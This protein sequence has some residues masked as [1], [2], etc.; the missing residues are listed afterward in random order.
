MQSETERKQKAVLKAARSL[1]RD[2]I[3][4]ARRA[5][6]DEHDI[7]LDLQ[8]KYARILCDSDTGELHEVDILVAQRILEK[9]IRTCRRIY[10]RAHPNTKDGEEAL[11]RVHSILDGLSDREEDV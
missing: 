11:E 2:L 6:G 7:T 9:N 4:E 8:R 5:L 1:A 10:G 3:P